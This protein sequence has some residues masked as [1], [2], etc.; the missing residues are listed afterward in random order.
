MA[1][2]ALGSGLPLPRGGWADR[3]RGPL[4]LLEPSV[5]WS[6]GRMS[7][8]PPEVGMVFS[9]SKNSSS[10]S[11]LAGGC[12]GAFGAGDWLGE[13]PFPPGENCPLASLAVG[14]EMTA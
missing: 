11:F 2:R 6:A 9:S 10:L 4:D 12:G 5:L 8:S 7:V 13:P 3:L 14:M 1:Q